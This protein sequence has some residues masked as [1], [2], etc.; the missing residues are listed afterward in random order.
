MRYRTIA[1]ERQNLR[2][3]SER[4]QKERCLIYINRFFVKNSENLLHS[5]YIYFG[6]LVVSAGA[7]VTIGFL[8]ESTYFIKS[9]FAGETESAVCA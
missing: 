9:A 2:K 6:F 1:K 4:A 3:Q 8:K 5:I 7:G